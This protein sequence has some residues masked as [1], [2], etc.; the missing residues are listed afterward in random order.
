MLREEDGEKAVGA[1]S[2]D[3]KCDMEMFREWK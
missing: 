1:F 2:C 3:R